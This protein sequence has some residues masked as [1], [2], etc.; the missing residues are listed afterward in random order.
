MKLKREDKD[1]LEEV[2]DKLFKRYQ[3]NIEKMRVPQD[4]VKYIGIVLFQK[5]HFQKVKLEIKLGE[6]S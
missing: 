1:F 4:L 2:S 6:T 5:L 3:L